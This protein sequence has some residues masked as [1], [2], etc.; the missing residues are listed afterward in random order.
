MEHLPYEQYFLFGAEMSKS[1]RNSALSYSGR[2]GL[3]GS[4]NKSNFNQRR[5]SVMI[6]LVCCG[7]SWPSLASVCVALNMGPQ[8]LL[9]LRDDPVQVVSSRGVRGKKRANE[10]LVTLFLVLVS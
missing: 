1:W 5:M 6:F 7:C 3:C 9:D 8:L 2:T 10:H 4:K